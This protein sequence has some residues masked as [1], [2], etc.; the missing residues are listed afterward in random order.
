MKSIFSHSPLLVLPAL[1]LVLGLS[2]PGCE[3]TDLIVEPLPEVH[4]NIPTVPTIPPPPYPVTYPDNSYSIWGLRNR[5]RNTL[6][7]DVEIT[8]Y[9]VGV[10]APPECDGPNCERPLAPRFWVAD[11]RGAEEDRLIVTGY[12]M[13]Q[14]EVDE[15]IRDARRGRYHPD[16]EAGESVIPTD[17]VVGNKIKLRGRFARMYGGDNDPN[18]LLVYSG[19][20]TLEA[21]EE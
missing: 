4:P 19:H 11:E 5:M 10:Y 8:A 3:S 15:A 17:L 16:P 14:T 20:E 9:V 21:V 13:N 7:S 2:L 18:G 1:S 12:A 6:D